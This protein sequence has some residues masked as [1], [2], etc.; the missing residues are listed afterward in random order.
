VGVGGGLAIQNFTYSQATVTSMVVLPVEGAPSLIVG[1][2]FDRAGSGVQVN[3]VA[4]WDGTAWHDLDGGVTQ[5][6]SWPT[7]GYI[8]S[9]ALFDDGAGAALY[10]GGDFVQAG[11][12]PVQGI[13][14]WREELGWSQV[15]GLPES[16]ASLCVHQ[17]SLYAASNLYSPLTGAVR[18]LEGG[19]WVPLGAPFN[20]H[21]A[22][23]A[24]LDLGGGTVL[25]AGGLFTLS[26]GRGIAQWDG[27]QWVPVGQ[28]VAGSVYALARAPG[29]PPSLLAGGAFS[30]PV[31]GSGGRNIARWMRCCY[32][33]C[34]ADGA[35]NLAD[36]GCFQTRFALADPYSDCNADAVFNLSDFGCFQTK[37]AL[38]CP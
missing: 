33:D 28:G 24:S 26:G 15:P 37:F 5:G 12:G 21:V 1:G 19:A 6:P 4:R 20:S 32:P 7:E 8:A 16:F 10:V 17:G 34:N 2:M 30:A 38:G 29:E 18:R 3:S 36:F 31:A 27:A 9:M 14:R 22:M 13:A 35:L 23:L 25:Y 11:A